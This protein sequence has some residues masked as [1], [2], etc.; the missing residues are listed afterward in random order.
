MQ[1]NND[2]WLGGNPYE[3]FMG[4][5]STLIAQRFLDWLSIPPARRWLDMGCGTGSLTKLILE[6]CHPTEIVSIDSSSEFISY[7]KQS[8][9]NPKAR[10]KVGLAQSLDLDSNSFD[11]VV[12]GLLLNFVPQPEM[13][14]SEMMRVAV[15]GRKIGIF[16][17]PHVVQGSKEMIVE[18]HHREAMSWIAALLW[19]SNTAIQIDAPDA[20]KP[21]Y[22]AKL[23]RLLSDMGLSTDHDIQS[24]FQPAK[25]LADD[26]FEV[27]DDIVS[28]HPEILD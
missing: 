11:A 5:W 22:Q 3:R 19:T 17:G 1:T 8:I 6:T 4:R 7:A 25:E 10:F 2:S 9:A 20:E 12:S 21:Q 24:R 26:V 18:G 27:A 23:N 16:L 14:V 15:P 28:R 13:A